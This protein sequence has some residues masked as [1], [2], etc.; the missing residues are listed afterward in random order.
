MIDAMRTSRVHYIRPPR[1]IKVPGPFHPA[2]FLWPLLPLLVVCGL[3]GACASGPR[4]ESVVAPSDPSITLTEGGIRLTILPNTWSAY[5]GNLARYYTPVEVRI[6]NTR[7]EELQIRYEDFVA[8]DDG[9]TQ[10]RAVPPAEVARA[11][12]GALDLSGPTGGPRP[13]LLPGRGTRTGLG[14]GAPIMTRMDP[15]GTGI[16]TTTPM[17]GPGPVRRTSCCSASAA[18]HCFPLPAC[19]DSSTS[20]RRRRGALPSPCPGPLAR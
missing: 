3:L 10:Y 9:K 2:R 4:L 18:A 11:L 17:R 19:K 7:D 8:L 1:K 16:P 15:G 12:F 6:E 20:S 13:V 14:I 5:P